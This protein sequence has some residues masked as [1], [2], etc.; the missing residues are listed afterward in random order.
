MTELLIYVKG[1]YGA[2][3]GWHSIALTLTWMQG[4]TFHGSRIVP[5]SLVWFRHRILTMEIEDLAK[6]ASGNSSRD[7][8]NMNEQTVWI[9]D[10]RSQADSVN[11]GLGT[12]VRP[13]IFLSTWI[14][15]MSIFHLLVHFGAR[16][17]T[18]K[19]GW[20]LIINNAFRVTIS[21]SVC[22]KNPS[23]TEGERNRDKDKI[24]FRNVSETHY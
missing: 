10:L 9:R 4:C 24:F 17:A 6:Y 8:R 14:W 11:P 21:R 16:K 1:K 7:F 19:L 5:S 3:S 13:F 2:H 15:C 22:L 23:N 18:P 12:E 20:G